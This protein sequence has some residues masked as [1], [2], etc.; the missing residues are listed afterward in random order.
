MRIISLLVLGSALAFGLAA[1]DR[2][3]EPKAS[4]P[5]SAA[6]TQP[7]PQR[8]AETKPAPNASSGSSGAN[9]AEP[10]SPKQEPTR[11]QEQTEMPMPGQA[12]DHSTPA[13][14]PKK[15]SGG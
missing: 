9:H 3:T 15:P 14:D 7:V 6:T 4:S 2:S 8:P 10:V 5:S 12:D 11:R 1:C 13:R